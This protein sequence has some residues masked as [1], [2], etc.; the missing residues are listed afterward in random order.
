ML[1]FLKLT[2]DYSTSP[3][4]RAFM[5]HGTKGHA[6]LEAAEDDLSE[7]EVMFNSP[8][9]AES[10]IADV[11]EIEAGKIIM[12][13]YKTSG[14]YKVAKAL[15]FRVIQ[16]ETG[17]IYKTGK[18]AGQAKTCNVLVRDEKYIEMWDWILQLNRYRIHW[19]QKDGRKIDELRIQCVARDGGT[20]IARSRGVF[21]NVYYFKVPIYPDKRI[22]AYF[23]KKRDALMLALKQGRWTQTCTADENWDGLRCQRY[24]DVAEFCSY[25]KYLF[26][27]QPKEKDMPIKG[28]TEARRLP[29]LGKI[30]LGIKKKSEKSG[31][32]YPAEVDYFI[33]DPQTPSPEENEKLKEEFIK[34][35]GEQPKQIKIMFPVAN[36]DVF[37]P[38]HYK[39][40]GKSTSLQCKGDG[41][42]AVCA[43]EEFTKDLEVI[44]KSE[45]GGPI[46]KCAGRE[47]PY[48]LK[49]PKAC[50]EVGTLQVLLPEMPGAGVWQI[51]T[52]SLNSIININSCIDFIRSAC[53]R[54]HMIPLTLERREQEISHEGKKGKHWILHINMSFRLKNLQQ[55]A[56]ID[57]EKITLE[58]PSP[59]ADKEDILTQENKDVN[60]GKDPAIA[61]ADSWKTWIN[62]YFDKNP[63]VDEDAVKRARNFIIDKIGENKE[64]LDYFDD[65][66][67]TIK[68]SQ[69][70]DDDSPPVNIKGKS[71]GFTDGAEGLK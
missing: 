26:E 21:R 1:A 60:I 55:L 50:S 13:D 42:E 10:G 16:E 49:K 48:Y 36:P 23:R 34:L 45:L 52:G 11:I 32:E 28:L 22:L 33:L 3:D 29:R 15:G 59:D 38:Q 35:Y 2:C 53:G 19:E 17:D 40:Y 43:T 5:I 71:E 46:V 4:G 70:P 68:D 69:V 56:N 47:C 41:Q 51:S 37:F 57:P 54:A 39:R 61:M 62:N 6:N 20:Y 27:H 63:N 25:G 65:V 18:R 31:K 8:D 9:D 64:V 30:R 24:C 14:S 44:G 66:V 67:S 58:L 12:T 7:L